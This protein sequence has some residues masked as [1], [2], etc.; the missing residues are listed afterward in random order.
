[1]D[2][3]WEAPPGA[4]LL[5]S[6][7][8]LEPPQTP[9]LLTQRVGIA[10]VEAAR[11]HRP[12]ATVGL[13]WPNDVLLD[14]RKLAGVLAQRSSASGPIVVGFGVNV[15]WSPWDAAQLQHEPTAAADRIAPGAVLARVIDILDGLGGDV[16]GRYR[17]LLL[18]LGQPVRVELP[19][20]R[21]VLGTAVDVDPTGRLVVALGSGRLERFDVGDIVHL[22]PV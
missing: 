8:F 14:G 5:C 6:I 11:E 4:N 17:E 13:K 21:S 1:L 22:R 9:A 7:A 16:G 3:R 12:D 19:G 2:R 18:T 20:N 15:G 10:L